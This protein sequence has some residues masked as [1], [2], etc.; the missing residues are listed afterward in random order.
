[1]S[2]EMMPIKSSDI[3]ELHSKKTVLT[4]LIYK[5]L[6]N[7]ENLS[8]EQ[9]ALKRS[10]NEIDLQISEMK[11]HSNFEYTDTEVDYYD[12]EISYK[13]IVEVDISPNKITQCCNCNSKC[14]NPCNLDGVLSRGDI[15]LKGCAAFSNNETC[16][17]CGHSIDVHTHTQKEKREEN[18]TRSIKKPSIRTVTKVDSNKKNI[19]SQAENKKNSLSSYVME[20]ER[21]IKQLQLN[22]NKAYRKI[23][24]IFNEIKSKSL[25]HIN[26]YFLDYIEVR[27]NAIKSNEKLN[28]K[29]LEN[30]LKEIDKC[31]KEYQM[32]KEAL[33]KDGK[34]EAD[35]LKELE[36]LVKEIELEEQKLF[37]K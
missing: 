5:E 8:N 36:I 18:A 21:S 13:K 17:V 7:V 29:E 30:E 32:K 22:L 10:L 28:S 16:K 25:S 24:F 4:N 27:E 33:G 11:K 37:S 19:Y 34:L 6:N 31:R 1:M 23:A 12:D 26:E 35:E 20:Q 9:L 15:N 2:L 3:K 14:H